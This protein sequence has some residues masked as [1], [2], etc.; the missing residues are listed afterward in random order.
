M[1]IA[2]KC[3]VVWANFDVTEKEVPLI[4]LSLVLGESSSE[5]F[6]LFLRGEYHPKTSPALAENYPKASFAL[7][8]AKGS[9][10][11]ILTKTHPVPTPGLR[12]GAPEANEQTSHL[13]VSDQRRPWTPAT[14]EESQK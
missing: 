8:Q 12:T 5:S 3:C 14:P 2:K 13:M 11:F 1:W 7:S 10:R 4:Q 9:A 6:L